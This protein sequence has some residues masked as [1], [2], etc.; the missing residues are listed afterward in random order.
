M[1]DMIHVRINSPAKV[2]WE[3]DADSVSSENSQG[4]FDILPMHTNFVSFVE[5]KPI[6]VKINDKSESYKFERSVIYAR[7][8]KV[9]IY[10]NF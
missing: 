2:I 4:P 3:G 1:T 6:I 5:N 7:E 9:N 10:T 8:N